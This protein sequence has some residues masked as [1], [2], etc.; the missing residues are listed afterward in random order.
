[1]VTQSVAVLEGRLMLPCWVIEDSAAKVIS[2]VHN[3]HQVHKTQN[4]LKVP[5]HFSF[6]LLNT[7]PR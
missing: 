1:M 4:T 7:I 2:D 5:E 3:C 6:S